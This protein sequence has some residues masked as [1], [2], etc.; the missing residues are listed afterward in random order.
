MLPNGD[1]KRSNHFGPELESS[2]LGLLMILK[3]YD[4]L[5]ILTHLVKMV[6]N[7]TLIIPNSTNG[8]CLP[9]PPLLNWLLPKRADRHSEA[10][11]VT[12]AHQVVSV[13]IP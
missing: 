7:F 10:A 5:T 1:D 8:V 13:P 3:R 11:T 6:N 2:V 4:L 9:G 12:F